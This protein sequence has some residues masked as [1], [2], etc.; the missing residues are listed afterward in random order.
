MTRP[1]V[2]LGLALVLGGCSR[3]PKTLGA[4]AESAPKTIAEARQSPA[5]T[6]LTLH[7]TMTKKCPIAGCWFMLR[8]ET[9]IIKVDTQAAGFVV[10]EVPL[11]TTLTVAGRVLTNSTERVLEATGVRY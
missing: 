10:V 2:L 6:V 1:F 3:E 7:G 9:G 5:D 11:N 4:F 8:D